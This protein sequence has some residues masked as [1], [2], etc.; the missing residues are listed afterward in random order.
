[1]GD[2]LG[3]SSGG[4][5]DPKAQASSKLLSPQSRLGVPGAG[6]SSRERAAELPDKVDL[7]SFKKIRRGDASPFGSGKVAGTKEV[8]KQRG[9]L[10]REVQRAADPHISR[11][12]MQEKLQK[13]HKQFHLPTDAYKQ[14]NALIDRHTRDATYVEKL[15][16]ALK[17]LG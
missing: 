17:A 10:Y 4:H 14:R 1:M 16:K 2:Y 6:P 5:V 12:E 11:Q 9:L 3:G 15:A 13:Y 8:S 7:K